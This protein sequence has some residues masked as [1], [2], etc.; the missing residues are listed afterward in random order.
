MKKQVD[1]GSEEEQEVETPKKKKGEK[2]IAQDIPT[3]TEPM[4]VNTEDG[5]VYPQTVINS[6]ILNKLEKIEKALLS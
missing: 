6:I 1:E 5:K 4:V 2:W 3:A